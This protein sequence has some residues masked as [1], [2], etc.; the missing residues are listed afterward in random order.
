MVITLPS[1]S[2]PVPSIKMPLSDS[3][4]MVAS[5]K[6]RSAGC[7]REAELLTDAAAATG[8]C[9]CAL[10][11]FAGSLPSAPQAVSRK[12]AV[13]AAERFIIVFIWKTSL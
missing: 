8:A 3:V 1:A 11:V 7:R 4:I 10:S 12:M 6:S 2:A 9:S 5:V 13:S